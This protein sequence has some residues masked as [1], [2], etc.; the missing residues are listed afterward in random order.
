MPEFDVERRAL[1]NALR[2]AADLYSVASCLVE[3]DLRPMLQ[4]WHVERL[5]FAVELSGSTGLEPA[6]EVV[7][8]AERDD[9]QRRIAS[10]IEA[11]AELVEHEESIL[12][13][14]VDDMPA[15][16]IDECFATRLTASITAV[17]QDLLDRVQSLN[18][19]TE[20]P[21]RGD[22]DFDFSWN[23][24]AEPTDTKA[25]AHIFQLWYAT[26]RA[27]VLRGGK[28]VGFSA[29]RADVTRFGQCDVTIPETHK[30]GG[31]RWWQRLG[32]GDDRLRLNAIRGQDEAS[33]WESVRLRINE[34]AVPGDAIVFIHGYNVS[35]EDAAIRA[36]QIGADLAI[37]G[38]MAFFSWP[39]RGRLLAYPADEATIEASEPPITQFLVD[40]AAESGARAVHVIAHSMGNRGLLRAVQRIAAS[41]AAQAAKPLGQ[42]I[43]AA[44]DVDTGTFR[45]LAAAY[46][47]VAARTT[48]YVSKAD[49]AVR[50]SRLL[51]GAD[52]IGYAP[53]V[54]IIP[55][56]DTVNITGVDMTLLGHGYVAE[57][58]SVLQ[59]MYELFVRGTAP[60]ARAMLRSRTD[61]AG[62]PYWEV[63]A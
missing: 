33:F 41:A 34:T 59:D 15:G 28:L 9:I 54:A 13:A 37:G 19:P 32:R 11:L 42:I 47:L 38:A 26:N 35:F 14:L 22:R 12:Q 6:D 62:A 7:T 21:M 61:A 56:I 50:S 29:D 55:G 46:P 44:P 4:R 27:P 43:L 8:T 25:T 31:S 30:I 53:P 2:H 60:T 58:R 5:D 48:L 52:R 36:A 17:R 57:S 39:S 63:A 16:A 51:H 10:S 40:F 18:R 45:A 20:R 24:P 3:T 49:L 23:H 1:V